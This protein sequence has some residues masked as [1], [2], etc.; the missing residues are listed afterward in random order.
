[1]Y[2]ITVAILIWGTIVYNKD[3]SGVPNMACLTEIR[4]RKSL[5]RDTY[6][7][8]KGENIDCFANS[9]NQK[10]LGYT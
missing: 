6:G 9:L 8:I 1:M 7:I 5:Q 2:Y 10:Y 3:K 4:G